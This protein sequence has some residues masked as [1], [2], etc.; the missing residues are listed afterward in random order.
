M[1]VAPKT[2]T[3]FISYSRKD[4]VF[5]DALVL[6]LE[7]RGYD[8]RI[9]RSD[10]TKGEEWW[11]RIVDLIVSLTLVLFVTSPDAVSSA[12]C[13]DEVDLTKRL[14]NELCP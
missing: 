13:A 7:A 2:T 10:I 6:A 8:V 11:K 9:D 1:T 12:V 3:L 4:A 14:G 5:V